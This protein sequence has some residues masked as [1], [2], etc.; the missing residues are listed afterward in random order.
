MAIMLY[1]TMSVQLSN[2]VIVSVYWGVMA[3]ENPPY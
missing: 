2:P 1:W 3:P